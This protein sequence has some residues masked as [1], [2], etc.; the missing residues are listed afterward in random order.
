MPFV[1]AA[2][3]WFMIVWTIVIMAG[4]AYVFPPLALAVVYYLVASVYLG[5]IILSPIALG[6]I[7]FLLW[8]KRRSAI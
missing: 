1:G 8:K 6:G 7:V 2:I 5:L 4:I 3:V